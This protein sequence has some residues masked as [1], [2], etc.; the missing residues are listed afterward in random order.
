M[1]G[2][3]GQV[4]LPRHLGPKGEDE[5]EGKA[6]SPAMHRGETW[7]ALF[8]RRGRKNADMLEDRRGLAKAGFAVSH[9]EICDFL[10][11]VEID[12]QPGQAP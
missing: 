7:H 3:R 10:T 9:H 8:E 2:G 1:V 11:C 6:W 12:N 5:D 4:K